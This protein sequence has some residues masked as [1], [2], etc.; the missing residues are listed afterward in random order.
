MPLNLYY[1][2][3]KRFKI[4]GMQKK[5]KDITEFFDSV[6]K[7]FDIRQNL[8]NKAIIS[9]DLVL[10]KEAANAIIGLRL[11]IKDN[12]VKKLKAGSIPAS[13]YIS[14]FYGDSPKAKSA[15]ASWL[16]NQTG[17]KLL[18]IDLSAVISKYKGETEKGLKELFDE[19]AI[20]DSILLFD[21]ADALFGKRTDIKDSHDRYANAGINY[22]L[23]R[24]ES[25]GGVIIISTTAKGN[26]DT[27]FLRR[28][29][30]IIHFPAK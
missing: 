17:L 9:N 11:W 29:Q 18:H 4:S 14:L 26:I 10:D 15:T 5:Y 22:F 8:L 1:A 6:E 24:A 13:G 19:M 25:S 2:S 21:E 12:I 23:Q 30:S 3:L 16:A 20:N 7:D 28:L 27:A